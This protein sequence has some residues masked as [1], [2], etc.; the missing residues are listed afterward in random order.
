MELRNADDKCNLLLFKNVVAFQNR[1][2]IF[3]D[4][5]MLIII[6]GLIREVIAVSSE[7]NLEANTLKWI[8]NIIKVYTEP[9]S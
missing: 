7:D 1:Q 5:E 6:S 3:D 4:D 2:F 8:D 9:I